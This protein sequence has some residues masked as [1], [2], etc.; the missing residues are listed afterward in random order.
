MK[1][2]Q[3][4]SRE[5][6]G[7][8]SFLLL[9]A[10]LFAALSLLCWQAYQPHTLMWANDTQFGAMNA[11]SSRL[12][13]VYKGE[14]LD[15][16][17]IGMDIPAA[18]PSI[19]MML[20][21]VV[22]PA[23]Y[24]KI[25]TPFSMLL[26]GFCAW[27]LFRQLKFAPMVCVLGGLA[28]GLNMHCFSNG[29]WGLGTWNVAIAMI[30]L[31]LAALVTDAIRQS[32]IKAILAGLAVGMSVMEGFDSGAILS[33]YAGVF[34]AF[35]CWITESTVPGKILK[36]AQV[37]ALVV[38]FAGL[39]A[40]STLYTLV[41][42]QVLGVNG[43]GESAEAKKAYWNFATQWSLPKA[44]T[45]RVIIPGIFGYRMDEFSTPPDPFFASLGGKMGGWPGRFMQGLEDKSSAYW[46]KVGEDPLIARLE[47]SDPEVRAEAIQAVGGA[48]YMDLMRSN[49]LVHRTMLVDSVKSQ[50]QRRHSGNG[51]YAG[52]VTALF[53]IFALLN[54]CRGK[55]CPYSLLERR[56]VWFWALATLFSLMAAWGRFSFVYGLLYQLPGVSSIRNPIK[57]M[58]PFVVTWVILAGFGLEAFHRCYLRSQAKPAPQREL[59]P[60]E[61]KAAAARQAAQATRR[62][63]LSPFD[64]AFLIGLIAVAIGVF[65]GFGLYAGSQANL[66]EYLTHQFSQPFTNEQASK[67]ASFSIDEARWFVLLFTLSAAVVVSVVALVWEQRWTWAPWTLLCGIMVFDL[68][69]ADL[70]W[71]RYFN[72]DQKYS[73]NDVTKILMDKPY[74]H[75]VNSRL[76]PRGGYDLPGDPNFGAIIHWWIEND[77]PYKDIQSLEID[78]MPRTPVMDGNYLNAFPYRTGDLYYN[79]GGS[80]TFSLEE[81]RDLSRIVERLRRQSDPV[82]AFLWQRLSPSE[83]SVLMSYQPSSPSSPQARTNVV[84]ALNRAV[85]EPSCI[86][87]TGRFNGVP[88]RPKTAAV[89]KDNP[90][91]PLVAYANRFLLE[92]AY[93]LELSRTLGQA[94]RM[95]KLTNTR[96]ILAGTNALPA[97]NDLGDPQPYSFRT[98]ERFNLVPKPGFTLYP[99][100][101]LTNVADAGDLTPQ[102]SAN[103]NCVLIEYTNVLPRAKL[104]SFWQTPP[105]D[106]ATLQALTAPL[107]DPAQSVLVS[108]NTPVPEPTAPLGSDP[109]VVSITS[110]KPKDI[111]LQASAKTAAVLL[112]NDRTADDWR[113]WVDGKLSPLLRCNYIMRGVY[114]PIG[115]HTVE[116]RFQPSI[117]PLYVT[118]SAF[119]V[120]ILLA[121]YLIWSRF[122][123]SSP[124]KAVAPATAG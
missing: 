25:F 34:T 77:F 57:F 104:Y 33:V 11:A 73:M 92:D 3:P 96:Y 9:L 35:L 70:P 30:F 91:G 61:A 78:Q 85:A 114:L 19:S 108:S 66:A 68:S 43:A 41:G 40:C 105:S 63:T 42:T 124:S 45:L 22:S 4:D 118:L 98:V 49:D 120:G 62:R 8:G 89:M 65:V 123:P 100:P 50:S 82:S 101:G 121:A 83:Q 52:V 26:L 10:I 117:A 16:W 53:A 95:W 18:S 75:R 44:E 109:G 81:I 38:F 1:D 111:R 7:G 110:Y 64:L 2:I 46:G 90:A 20:A 84:Q 113:V 94:P 56:M 74:E 48:Q 28:A 29:S 119:A 86:Y 106:Q 99:T 13:D 93:P 115:E 24:L 58:H 31:A 39:I 88:L 17:W 97:L 71:V 5:K 76:N 55:S 12:P 112:Y 21:T 14:W 23:L 27:V 67:I 122:A 51:E 103:G 69:R 59:R 102:A 87:D 60:A 79:I 116:F 72:Y 80:S 37:G 107:W 47:S 36:S 32:W 54:S 6:S 15:F